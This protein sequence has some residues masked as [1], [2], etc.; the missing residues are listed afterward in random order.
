MLEI[1]FESVLTQLSIID[2]RFEL[3]LEDSKMIYNRGIL[4]TF[5]L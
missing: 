3:A 5:S 4:N 2:W 1:K